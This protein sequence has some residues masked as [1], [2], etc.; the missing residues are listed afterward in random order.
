MV[1]A[2]RSER[3][4][5]TTLTTLVSSGTSPVA[6]VMEMSLQWHSTISSQASHRFADTVGQAMGIYPPQCTSN[7]PALS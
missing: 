2:L 1:T 5:I 7:P 3:Q 6:E 4:P